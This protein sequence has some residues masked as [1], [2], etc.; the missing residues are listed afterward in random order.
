MTELSGENSFSTNEVTDLC[1][2]IK[3]IHEILKTVGE[4]FN[5]LDL[6]EDKNGNGLLADFKKWGIKTITRD[7]LDKQFQKIERIAQIY[8]EEQKRL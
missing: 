2:S 5:Q 7:M 1:D 4:F 8:K 6:N 3:N